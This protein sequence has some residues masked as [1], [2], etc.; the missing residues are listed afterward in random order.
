M[1]R[2]LSADNTPTEPLST[3]PID[4]QVPAQLETATFAVG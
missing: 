3:P 1:L 4:K 2:F